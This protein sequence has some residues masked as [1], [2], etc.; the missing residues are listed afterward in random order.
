MACQLHRA[1]RLAVA[2]HALDP[3]RACFVDKSQSF[4]ARLS[5]VNAL[6]KPYHPHFILVTRSPYA[7][8]YRAAARA[9]HIS[10]LDRPL[11][12]RLRL[13]AQHWRNSHLC[14]LQDAPEVERFTTIRLEDLLRD[15]ETHLRALCTF[16]QLSFEP[17]MVP[18]PEHHIPLGS[19]GSAPG[20][21]KWYPLRP[22]V[23]G[24]YLEA[25]EPWMVDVVKH[26]V[27][28]LAERWEYTPAGP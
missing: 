7:M 20:H 26:Y 1:I 11:E 9:T 13:A 2:I 5:L 25:L 10:R 17:D 4:T 3:Q 6:L 15:P 27:G 18:A 28:E 19:T 21:H 16:T 22:D 8:V 23:N 12:D 24:M 14:A